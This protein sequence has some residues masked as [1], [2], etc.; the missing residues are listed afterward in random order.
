MMTV[1]SVC[2]EDVVFLS[3]VSRVYVFGIS[4]LPTDLFTIVELEN[5][6]VGKFY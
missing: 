5:P 6:S 3:D 4:D 1:S 2:I